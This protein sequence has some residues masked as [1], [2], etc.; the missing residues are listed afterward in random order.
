[1]WSAEARKKIDHESSDEDESES[2]SDGDAAPSASGPV[3]EQTREGRRD[4]KKQRKAALIA[5]RKAKVVEVGDMPPSDSDSEG[6]EEVSIPANSNH[7]ASARSQATSA[8]DNVTAGVDDITLKQKGKDDARQKAEDTERK[9]DLERLA[10][11]KERRKFA[12]EMAEM[13]KVTYI[14]PSC[15]RPLHMHGSSSVITRINHLVLFRPKQMKRRP[16]LKPRVRQYRRKAA[17]RTQ[18]NEPSQP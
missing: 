16:R 11:I 15:M 2:E 1:M 10:A 17:R 5:E 7:T 18:G 4:A 6:D 12:A 14:P 8:V 13:A 9:A 3:T